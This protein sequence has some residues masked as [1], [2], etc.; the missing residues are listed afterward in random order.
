MP[1]TAKSSEPGTF[2]DKV[3]P[4]TQQET[5]PKTSPTSRQSS[6]GNEPESQSS[7]AVKTPETG[8]VKD[9]VPPDLRRDYS[10]P[11][12]KSERVRFQEQSLAKALPRSARVP[13]A[14]NPK[15]EGN[16][17]QVHYAK[18]EKGRL[19]GVHIQAGSQAT[20]RDIELHARTVKT[21]KRYSGAS[22]RVQRI[23]DKIEGRIKGHGT[24][25]VGSKAW[26]AKLEVDKLQRIINDR[27]KRLSQ[28]NLSAQEKNNLDK[29]ITHLE[30]QLDGY[31]IDLDNRD[32]SQGKG[33]VAAES[34]AQ[35]AKRLKLEKAKK[36]AK[37]KG[38]DRAADDARYELNKLSR[39]QRGLPELSREE[40]EL[41]ND[42]AHQNQQRGRQDEDRILE[43]VGVENNNY[44]TTNDGTK[45]NVVIHTTKDGVSTRPDGISDTHWIDVKSKKGDDQTVYNTEQIKAE[46]EGAMREGKEHAVVISGSDLSAARPSGGKTGLSGKSEVYHQ[47]SETGAW[48]YWNPK[49]NKGQGGWTPVDYEDVK[50][51]LGGQ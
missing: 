28:G 25:E 47:N 33:F 35:K 23:K 45:R 51:S 48:S 34:P 50:S 19:T 42:R 11:G 27:S 41:L 37:E 13:V 7:V 46:R 17:V 3:P 32:S 5:P 20:R 14:V 9:K 22:Y 30:H 1:V 31:K 16:T 10:Q 8:L 44:A 21:L 4:K 12:G 18:D 49:A 39:E 38:D 29:E 15:L 40:W 2:R 36:D 43:D 24:L 26:E 6:Q